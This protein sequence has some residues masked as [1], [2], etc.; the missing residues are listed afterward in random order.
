VVAETCMIADAWATALMVCGSP[1]GADLARKHDLD[2][3]FIDRE[4]EQFRE[5]RVGPLFEPRA[6]S[7]L[8]RIGHSESRPGFQ[9]GLRAK[10][11]P[12]LQPC[13][14]LRSNPTSD[15]ERHFP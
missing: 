14:R 9:G 15:P 7:S 1:E 3:L 13:R 5:T 10:P 4:G 8:T 6:Q 12:H 11:T 2:A